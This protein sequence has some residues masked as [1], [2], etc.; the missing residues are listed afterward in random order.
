MAGDC[1]G[2]ASHQATAKRPGRSLSATASG[3]PVGSRA[4]F[5]ATVTER[6]QMGL[7]MRLQVAAHA[8]S[9]LVTRTR[10]VEMHL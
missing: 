8:L 9:R 3:R 5:E 7:R 6:P 2:A 10:A 4:R 1:Q